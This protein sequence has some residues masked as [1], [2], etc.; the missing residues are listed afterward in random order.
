MP[1]ATFQDTTAS[2]PNSPKAGNGNGNGNG[3]VELVTAGG[4][5]PKVALSDVDSQ[6]DDGVFND[7]HAHHG[8]S[9]PM[10]GNATETAQITVNIIISFVGAG[11]LGIPKAFSRAGWFLGSVAAQASVNSRHS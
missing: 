7:P 5:R 8:P 4:R 6:E 11:L 2:P 9:I 10:L 1:S 3:M